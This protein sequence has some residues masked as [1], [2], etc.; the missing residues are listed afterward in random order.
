MSKCKYFYSVVWNIET[1][2]ELSKAPAEAFNK[3]EN[4]TFSLPIH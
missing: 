1:H 3:D 4:L 2:N